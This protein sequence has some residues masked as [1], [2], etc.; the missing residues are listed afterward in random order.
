M[1]SQIFP[2][3]LRQ[4]VFVIVILLGSVALLSGIEYYFS[5]QKMIDN[6]TMFQYKK[7]KRKVCVKRSGEKNSTFKPVVF[8]KEK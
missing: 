8:N 5:S 3:G 6:S 1:K 4:V 7:H 2:L